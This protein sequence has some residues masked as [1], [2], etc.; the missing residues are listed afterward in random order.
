MKTIAAEGKGGGGKTTSTINLA[1]AARQQGLKVGLVD[2][3]PQ[4]SLRDW[5]H[6]RG[7]ADI[8][9]RSCRVGEVQEVMSLAER[10][11]FDALF[12]DMPPGFGADTLSV[13]GAAD[14]VLL[15]MRST[16][17]DFAVTRKWDEWLRSADCRYGAVINAAPARR[18]GADAPSVR[19]A[20]AALLRLGVPHWAGQISHRLSIP[21][22]NIGGRGVVETDPTGPAAY[23]YASLWGAICRYLNLTRRIDHEHF[24]SPYAA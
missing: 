4:G 22:A 24:P 14:F 1:L 23:E 12:V 19:D 13:I 16:A 2:A 6:A 7:S 18:Q 9:V 8:P 21:Q 11:G 20:R 3:D 17:I 5:R 15:P 10:G